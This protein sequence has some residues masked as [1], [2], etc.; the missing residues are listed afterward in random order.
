VLTAEACSFPFEEKNDYLIYLVTEPQDVR[1]GLCTG[2]KGLA[3]A[4]LEVK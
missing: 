1:T 2:S 4:E 3:G